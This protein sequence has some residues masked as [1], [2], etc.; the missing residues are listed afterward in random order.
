[1]YIGDR[2]AKREFSILRVSKVVSGEAT[3][4]LYSESVFRFALA[5]ID[6]ALHE[7]GFLD[8]E[9]A[10]HVKKCAPM[11]KMF[12]LD[13]NGMS[14]K[15]RGYIL[16]GLMRQAIDFFGGIENRRRSLRVRI[17][18]CTDWLVGKEMGSF[19]QQF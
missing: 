3:E 10:D 2:K 5:N 17:L 1:M 4:I 16:N 19:C 9:D 11:V 6:F 15:W 14:I 18:S 8:D 12:T 7:T 13:I